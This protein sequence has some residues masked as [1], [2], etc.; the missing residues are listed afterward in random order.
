[1]LYTL[2]LTRHP[3]SHCIVPRGSLVDVLDALIAAGYRDTLRD[4]VHDLQLLG[5]YLGRAADG[6]YVCVTPSHV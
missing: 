6:A 1:M 4:V 2:T 3:H 5:Q